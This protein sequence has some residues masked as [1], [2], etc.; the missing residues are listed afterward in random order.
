VVIDAYT[1]LVSWQDPDESD[2][3]LFLALC[4]MLQAYACER[5]RA[6]ADRRGLSLQDQRQDD[7]S[8]LIRL[9]PKPD[10]SSNETN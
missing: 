3:E 10:Q 9:V 4:Q 7:G 1:G 8:V 5:A 2:E 6:E